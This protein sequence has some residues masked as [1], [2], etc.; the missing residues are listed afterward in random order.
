MTDRRGLAELLEPSADHELG[1]TV[2]VSEI[3]KPEPPS[4]FVKARRRT[5]RAF[6]E[7]AEAWAAAS[8]VLDDTVPTARL[9]PVVVPLRV[10]VLYRRLRAFAGFWEWDRD[11]A[12]RGA[13]I[14]GFVMVVVLAALSALPFASSTESEVRA[15]RTLEQHT[16]LYAPVRGRARR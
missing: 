9:G 11:D 14:G 8:D 16:A 1:P 6:A 15:P 2:V 10:L 7:L 3:D 12:L 13:F 4:T 5:A